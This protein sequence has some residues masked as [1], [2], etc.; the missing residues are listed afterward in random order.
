MRI[1]I[2]RDIYNIKNFSGQIN[3]EVTSERH[4]RKR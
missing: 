1:L 2:N 4:V 3:C